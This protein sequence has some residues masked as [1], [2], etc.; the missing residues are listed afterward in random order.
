MLALL[1]TGAI[2]VMQKVH[3]TSAH[4][5]ELTLFLVIAFAVSALASLAFSVFFKAEKPSE[6]MDTVAT[7]NTTKKRLGYGM[8]LLLVFAGVAAAL[9]NV[10]NL[11][12]SG[13]MD[14]AV[15]FPLVNGG[16]LLL[17]TLCS[18][19]FYKE[20]FTFAQWIGIACGIAAVLCLCL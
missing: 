11:H 2:G 20:K 15:F 12:L 10:I 18:A 9:N 4:K 8:L 6:N 5:E 16:N 19:V 7:E 13:V 1:A 14:S 3:Q 17:V